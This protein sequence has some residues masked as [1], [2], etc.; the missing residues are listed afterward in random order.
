MRTINDT[1]EVGEKIQKLVKIFV[2]MGRKSILDIAAI[3]TL[4][5]IP[6][7]V[8]CVIFDVVPTTVNDIIYRMISLIVRKLKNK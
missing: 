7:F 8:N 4:K 6:I 1:Q 3:G 2:K 5:P